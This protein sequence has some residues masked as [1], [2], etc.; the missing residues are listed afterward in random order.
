[1]LLFFSTH[2]DRR[3]GGAGPFPR[4]PTGS[5]AGSAAYANTKYVGKLWYA[6]SHFD[7]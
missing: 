3:P 2:P 4:S 1:M 6:R 7:S 5:F